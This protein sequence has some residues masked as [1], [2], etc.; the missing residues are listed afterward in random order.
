[1]RQIQTD[2]GLAPGVGSDGFGGW[3]SFWGDKNVAELEVTLPQPWARPD[4]HRTDPSSPGPVWEFHPR[5]TEG[6]STSSGKH[7]L[8]PRPLQMCGCAWRRPRR[9]QKQRWRGLRP[10]PRRF[11]QGGCGPEA[12]NTPPPHSLGLR[13]TH[14]N[15]DSTSVSNNRHSWTWTEK[16]PTSMKTCQ[17]KIKTRSHLN[18]CW[19]LKAGGAGRLPP[20]CPRARARHSRWEP[21]SFPISLPGAPPFSAG[22]P[23][24]SGLS[25]S[26]A[27]CASLMEWILILRKTT[28]FFSL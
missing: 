19:T 15:G 22:A 2:C 25:A 11:S 18:V 6:G 5:F 12:G 16:C 14:L 7:R 20:R 17:N 10:G 23:R 13:Q 26:P 27:R 4:R 8:R 28:Q 9:G 3:V 24:T 21:R 1:M